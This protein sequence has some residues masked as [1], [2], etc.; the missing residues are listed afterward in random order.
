MSIIIF[1]QPIHSG[2]STQL[3]HWCDQQKN[4]AGIVMPDMDGKRKILN[5]EPKEVFAIECDNP[6]NTNEK[7]IK[8]GK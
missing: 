4:V 2:K 7:L 8:G 5:L 1:S 6:A 3:L